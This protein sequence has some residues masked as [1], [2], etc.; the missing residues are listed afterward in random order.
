MLGK[1]F[2]IAATLFA[3]CLSG[4][5]FIDRHLLDVSG[6]ENQ[7][8]EVEIGDRFYFD[9]DENLTTGYSWDYTCPDSDLEVTIEHKRNDAD[10][11][12]G[13]GGKADVRVRVKQGFRGPSAVVFNYSRPWE[14]KKPLKS[15]QILFYFHGVDCSL[16]R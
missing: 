11:M 14:K 9:L 16:F 13:V 2:S 12:T 1:M 3:A 5:H 8:V 6:L 10:G 4:C 15:F 7:A